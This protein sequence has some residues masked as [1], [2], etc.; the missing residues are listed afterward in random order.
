MVGFTPLIK[1]FGGTKK[2]FVFMPECFAVIDQADP[3]RRNSIK[4]AFPKN[5]EDFRSLMQFL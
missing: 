4:A 3:L 1:R 5:P 2:H